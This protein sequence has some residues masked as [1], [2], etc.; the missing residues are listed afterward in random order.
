MRALNAP[1]RLLAG[2]LLGA[3]A[4]V[5]ACGC[6]A[7]PAAAFNGYST[8]TF[9]GAAGSGDGQFK[10]PAGVAV[11]DASKEV[12]VYDSGNLRVE[13]FDSTGAKFEGQF[14]GSGAPTGQFAAPATISE[15]AA[16]GTL[17][18]LAIDNDA[19]SPSFGDVYVVD[20][21]HNVIDKL[22]ATG[23]YLSQ[24][25]GFSATVFGVAVDS[26]GDVWV[27]EE[28]KEEPAPVGN[29]GPV[30]RFDNALV[31]NRLPELAS[32]EALRSPG[33][34]V[35]T[36]QNLFLLRGEPN[37]IKFDK[38]GATLVGQL[39]TCNCGTGLGLDTSSNDLFL[40]GRNSIFRYLPSAG[41]TEPPAETIGG[42]TASYGVAV[43]SATHLLYATQREAN[44]VAIFNFGLL[45]DVTTG[46]AN[47]IRRTT[48]KLEGEVNPDGQEVTS[49]TFEYGPTEAYGQSV[50]CSALPGSGSSPV[51][52]SAEATGLAAAS[53]EHFRL[54][55]GN[56]TGAHAGEDQTLETPPAVEGLLAEGAAALTG[57]SAT[58]QG[59]FEP[60]GF[61]THYRFEYR[62]IGEPASFTPL[63]DGGSAS[64][65]EHVSA[66]VT[67]LTPNAL[68]VFQ[69]I[70]ENQ[71]GQ[72]IGGPG[73][74]KT[75]VLAPLVPGT[76]SASFIASQSA[77]L[78]GTLNPENTTTHY[79]FEYGACPTLA[80]CA[81]VQ[82]T[83]DETSAVYGQFGAT[84]EIRGLAAATTYAY[85]LVADNEFEEEPGVFAGGKATGIEGH[86]TT[87][88]AVA[89]HAETGPPSQIS[90]TTALITATVDSEGLPTA[91][92][93]ELGIYNGSETQYGTIY[94]NSASPT[95][96]PTEE[97][98]PL[99]GLQ[100]GTTYAYRIAVSS[101]YILNSTHTLQGATQTF[102]T[103]GLPAALTAPTVMAQ[104]P[105][106]AIAFP[107][108]PARH[109]VTPRK[110]TRAQLLTNALRA[111]TRQPKHRRAAC[112]RLAEKR[113][114]ARQRKR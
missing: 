24:L 83:P 47:E 60:N 48:A 64:E 79:H 105:I 82:S 78:N 103:A 77:D 37:V 14:N 11:N 23:V 4:I 26:S 88:A 8:P 34:A 80:G 76:P 1:T 107:G 55:A 54:I 13:R 39:S 87:L 15:H 32:P 109:D 20:P 52:V 104:L 70:A 42:L 114:G 27:A 9:F 28:G 112:R 22:S 18:N 25:T 36:E 68:Y 43:N 67:G 53:T 85:H 3:A 50:P 73:I 69:I 71:F 51:T 96:G 16:H 74:F 106:P 75:P 99:S 66:E 21:G 63:Q 113:Y 97:S 49:C 72:S 65:D 19:S 57:T 35:D 95:A 59:S 110:L 111:C 100:P 2:T 10:E 89:P 5:L 98:I 29:I 40:D 58:L 61:D 94:T 7:R 31:N 17:F 38:E 93:F 84:Q 91:Y 81:S 62:S 86:F 46:T 56:A 45:P 6:L 92:S 33:I 101:G 30:Q 102:T 108:E 90:S 44:T 41:A 12:Y